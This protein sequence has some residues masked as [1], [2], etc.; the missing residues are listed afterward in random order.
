[1]PSLLYLDH[2]G[3]S[4][5]PLR[6]RPFCL[7]KFLRVQVPLGCV[8]TAVVT[9]WLGSCEFV[10][11]MEAGIV[12]ANSNP[13]VCILEAFVPG[14]AF[15]ISCWQ[16]SNFHSRWWL[17]RFFSVYIQNFWGNDPI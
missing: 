9:H 6:W 7:E 13:H 15:A 14:R 11:T 17:Q 16:L 5:S 1:M 8:K 12:L 10:K 2:P 3:P 4:I